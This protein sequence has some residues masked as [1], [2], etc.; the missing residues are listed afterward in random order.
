MPIGDLP[1]RMGNFIQGAARGTKNAAGQLATGLKEGFG[2]EESNVPDDEQLYGINP[3]RAYWANALADFS[4]MAQGHPFQGMAMQGKANQQ[5]FQQQMKQQ[6]IAEELKRQQLGIGMLNAMKNKDPSIIQEAKKLYPNDPDKQRKYVEDY[7]KKAGVQVN[8]GQEWKDKLMSNIMEVRPEAVRAQ[9]DV[10]RYDAMLELIPSLGRT[11]PGA[12]AMTTFRGFLDQ[13]GMNELAGSINA[14]SQ[15][16]GVD[17]FSGDQ[18]ARELFRAL[19]NQDIVGRARELYP[20]SDSDIRILKQTAA[21]LS[22]QSD[23]KALEALIR[24]QKQERTST[25]QYYDWMRSMM[26]E[27]VTPPPGIDQEGGMDLRG[28]GS[29]REELEALRRKHGF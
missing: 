27:G 9:Q 21:T 3:R 29:Q 18:G 14:V 20:V 7:R 8:M 16:A 2:F 25:L 5:R 1:G 23:P 4:N 13:M 24:E 11:G 10:R 26:P 15:V 12:E 6:K 19:S 17:F 28:V 22:G